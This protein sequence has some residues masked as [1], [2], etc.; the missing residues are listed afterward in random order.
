M[1]RHPKDNAPI[2]Q[3]PFPPE[4]QNDPRIRYRQMREQSGG[5]RRR[6]AARSRQRQALLQD[7]EDP[8]KVVAARG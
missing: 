7:Q 4:N 5:P 3:T 8:V 1:K 2:P 6:I